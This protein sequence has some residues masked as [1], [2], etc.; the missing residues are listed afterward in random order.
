[1]LHTARVE[2]MVAGGRDD[3]SMEVPGACRVIKG[4][5]DVVWDQELSMRIGRIPNEE[6][7]R[8]VS[9]TVY[10]RPH[11]L[12]RLSDSL[13]RG[14][15]SPA[16]IGR[17][18]LKLGRVPRLVGDAGTWFVGWLPL[19]GRNAAGAQLAVQLALTPDDSNAEG[20][21]SLEYFLDEHRGGTPRLLSR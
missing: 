13:F 5:G 12:P 18:E 21:D 6:D 10:L 20:L 3:Y 11:L 14:G 1:M 4:L 8:T 7:E 19:A 2:V 9:L 16:T 15:Q 17:A